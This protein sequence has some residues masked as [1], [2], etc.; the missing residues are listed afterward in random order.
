[1]E[2][3][4]DLELKFNVRPYRF[5]VVIERGIDAALDELDK[6]ILVFLKGPTRS[7]EILDKVDISRPALLARLKRLEGMG[8]VRKSGRGPATR[9]QQ[10]DVG[11]LPSV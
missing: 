5:D 6:T 9:Y 1:M 3:R 2:R 11:N 10:T 4:K 8:L 7:G